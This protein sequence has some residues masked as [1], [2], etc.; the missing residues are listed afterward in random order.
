[1]T[2]GAEDSNK[3]FA[4]IA[5]LRTREEAIWFF[6]CSILLETKL[7]KSWRCNSVVQFLAEGSEVGD[8][9]GGSGG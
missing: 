6:Y 5:P 7:I 8:G 2:V 4:N 1:M 9:V 3:R